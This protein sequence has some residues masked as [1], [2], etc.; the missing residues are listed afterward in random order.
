MKIQSIEIQNFK[1]LEHFM[2]ETQNKNV[3]LLGENGSGKTSFVCA[4]EA[5]LESSRDRGV[6]ERNVFMEENAKGSIKVVI[7]DETNPTQDFEFSS[8]KI[9]EKEL[10]ESTA[11]NVDAITRAAKSKRFLEYKQLLQTYFL[12]GEKVNV[13]D[14]L[15]KDL[16]AEAENPLTHRNLG[17]DWAELQKMIPNRNTNKQVEAINIHLSQFNGALEEYLFDI[18]RDAMQFLS[19]F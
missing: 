5:F 19:K 18:Q 3:V 8:T 9:D 1:G 4:L 15:V 17:D 12:Q 16:L 7:S 10:V 2:L 13:F 14:L 11:R 6:F